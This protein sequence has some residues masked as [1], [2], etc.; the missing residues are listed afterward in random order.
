M[1][2]RFYWQQFLALAAAPVALGLCISTIV[3][4]QPKPVPFISVFVTKVKPDMSRD[5]EALQKELN[6]ALRKGGIPWRSVS[7]TALFGDLYTFVSVT[8]IEKFAQFDGPSTT[9]KALGEEG[10]ANL[11]GK[12]GRCTVEAHRYAMHFREELSIIKP[13]PPGGIAVVSFVRVAPGKRLEYEKFVKADV[14]PAMKKLDVGYSVYEPV[15]GGNTNDWVS[16][17]TMKGFGDLD[18]GVPIVRA[19]GQAGADKIAMKAASIV[20]SLERIVSRARPDLS[21]LPAGQ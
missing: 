6:A 14:M 13:G 7:Q 19:L 9:V 2:I 15:I 12:L 8:P 16:V 1:Q 21:Y 17:T 10:S 20:S 5:W 11:L 4:A 18:S 3:S